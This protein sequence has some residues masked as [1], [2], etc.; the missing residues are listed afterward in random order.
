MRDRK[1]LGDFHRP[2]IPNFLSLGLATVG[3]E[4]CAPLVEVKRIRDC[5]SNRSVEFTTGRN[6]I[7]WHTVV[8]KIRV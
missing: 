4:R 1:R 5:S 3:R 8:V 6:E 7:Q 2:S